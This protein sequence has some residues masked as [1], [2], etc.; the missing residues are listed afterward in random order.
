MEESGEIWKW[1]AGL[2][3]VA[4]LGIVSLLLKAWRDEA[5]GAG[6][7]F[8]KIRDTANKALGRIESIEASTMPQMREAFNEKI[9][10][11]RERISGLEDREREH[12]KRH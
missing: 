3:G 6:K 10:D 9:E 1:I 8:Q 7:E 11:L 5:M 2:F 4:L 12:N